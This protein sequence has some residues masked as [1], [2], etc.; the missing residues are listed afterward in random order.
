MAGAA[1]IVRSAKELQ[2]GQQG[3][4]DAVSGLGSGTSG[5]FSGVNAFFHN[6]DN[7]LAL[8]VCLVSVAGIYRLLR[9]E[10]IIPAPSRPNGPGLAGLF[11]SPLVRRMVLRTLLALVLAA[12][13]LAAASG[14]LLGLL[15]QFKSLF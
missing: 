6:T 1:D 14:R 10:H 13:G 7:L 3:M 9:A 5:F 11:A 4:L 2:G 8:G 12:L 15:G